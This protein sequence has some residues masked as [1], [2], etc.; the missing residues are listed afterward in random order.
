MLARLGIRQK[1]S[2]LLLIPLAAVVLVMVPFTAERVDDAR[3]AQAT[4]DSALAAREIGSLIQSLQ[5]E[6]LMALGYL[7]SPNLDRSAL[8]AQSETAADIAARLA[9]DPLTGPAMAL[10]AGQ[11][12]ALR[13]VR[14]NVVARSIAPLSAYDH[15]REA[16]TALLDALQLNQPPGADAQGL[17]QLGALDALMRSNEEVTSAGAILVAAAG[18]LDIDRELIAATLTADRLHLD[19]FDQL[20]TSTQADYVASI[21]DG[22]AAVRFDDLVARTVAGAG[23]QSSVDVSDALTGAL[24]YTALRRLAQ[25]RIAREIAIGAEQRASAALVTAIG[26]VAGAVVVFA[27]VLTLGV[28]VSRSISRPLRRLTRAAGVV[29]EVARNELVR[30]SDSESPDQ[31]PPRLAAIEVDSQDEIG[32][33]AAALNRVQATAA[34]LLERQVSTRGNIAV[35]FANIARR[36]QNLVGRQLTLIDDLERNERNP[37]LL[38]RLYRLDHVATRLRRSADSLLVVSGTIDQVMSGVPTALVDVIRS[39][40]AEIEGFRAVRLGEIPDVAVNATIVGDLRL[41]LAELLENATNFSPPGTPVEV[42]GVLGDECRIVVVDHGLGM[43]AARLDEENRRLVDRERLDVAPTTVLGLFVVGRL[44][45]RHGMTVQLEPSEGRGVT[46]FIR[47]PVRLLNVASAT[48]SAQK[49]PARVRQLPPEI[50]AMEAI[51]SGPSG[52]FPWFAPPTDM[53]AIAATPEPVPPEPAVGRASVTQVNAASVPLPRRT[54]AP[55]TPE[56]PGAAEPPGVG[57]PPGTPV[58]A[59]LAASAASAPNRSGLTQRVPGSH[60]VDAVRSQSSEAPTER[61]VRDPDAER[62]AM[63]DYLSGLARG[64]IEPEQPSRTTFAERHS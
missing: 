16:T 51:N 57:G 59:D 56:S 5:Q 63:N 14:R 12:E 15:Y 21:D 36:T 2:L 61:I 50:E 42:F 55:G 33:L 9:A 23:G 62:D 53:V 3:S 54:V 31:A 13:A 35:M 20:V 34:L 7:A 47:I 28:T 24:S 11:L 60:M 37:D 58:A 38:Q 25:D 26:V 10:A 39:A 19:R 27:I 17:G 44:A 1:L 29:A 8:V 52:P 64:G 49:P 43:S 48:P 46:A 32:E 6:R 22:Q 18:R 4:A 41:M 30:V 45:R 40:L